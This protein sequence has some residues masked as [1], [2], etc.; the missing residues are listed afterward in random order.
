MIKKTVGICGSM[1]VGLQQTKKKY[2]IL[3][4]GFTEVFNKC[5]KKS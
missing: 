3:G 5:T 1:I 4:L 2:I